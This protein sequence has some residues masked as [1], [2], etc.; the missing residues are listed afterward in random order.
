MYVYRVEDNG[1]TYL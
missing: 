1:S